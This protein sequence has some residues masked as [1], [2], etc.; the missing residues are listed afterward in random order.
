VIVP[1]DRDAGNPRPLPAP[2]HEIGE[3]LR[4][5]LGIKLDQV[6]D[7]VAEARDKADAIPSWRTM[8][9][10]VGELVIRLHA[11]ENEVGELKG[12]RR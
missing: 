9:E 12:A 5:Y 2:G 1:A 11:L 4:L 7:L 6:D 8:T 3:L 10:I